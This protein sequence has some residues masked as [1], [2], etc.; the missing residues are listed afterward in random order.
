MVAVESFVNSVLVCVVF[1]SAVVVGRRVAFFVLGGIVAVGFEAGAVDFVLLDIFLARSSKVIGAG[2]LSVF[3]TVGTVGGGRRSA[4]K[5]K[6]DCL[7]VREG[8][9]K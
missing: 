3:V 9:K 6:L 8:G 2:V 1:G 4:G 5:S 7:G